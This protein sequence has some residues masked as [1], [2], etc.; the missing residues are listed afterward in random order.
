M[1]PQLPPRH[2]HAGPPAGD[3]TQTP[4]ATPGVDILAP[5]VSYFIACRP[6]IVETGTLDDLRHLSRTSVSVRTGEPITGLN[7]RAGV[8]NVLSEGEHVRFDADTE[9]LPAIMRDLA[10]H[11]VQAITAAPPTLEQLLLRHYGDGEES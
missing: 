4:G 2:L 7:E 1:S 6:R 10:G 8:H 9:H 3:I 5:S 11:G